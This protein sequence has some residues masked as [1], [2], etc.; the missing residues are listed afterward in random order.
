MN[1]DAV[2]GKATIVYLCQY[3][4]KLKIFRC[5]VNCLN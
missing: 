3:T 1:R 2:K 5:T 4:D